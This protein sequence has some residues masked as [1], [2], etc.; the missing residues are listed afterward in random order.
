MWCAAADE[1]GGPVLLYYTDNIS[2]KSGKIA[3]QKAFWLLA[4]LCAQ[5]KRESKK[6]WNSCS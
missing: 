1:P 2:R 4:V 3:Q 6:Y 5:R